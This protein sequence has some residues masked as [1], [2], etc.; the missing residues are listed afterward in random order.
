[1]RRLKFYLRAVFTRRMK[2]SLSSSFFL[3]WFLCGV[4]GGAMLILGLKD[5]A[6]VEGLSQT[7]LPVKVNTV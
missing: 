4:F 2:A 5:I 6:I 7:V 3:F 1:M